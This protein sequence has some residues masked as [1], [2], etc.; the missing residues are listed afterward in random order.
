MSP[1]SIDALEDFEN[2]LSAYI[3]TVLFL[4][5]IYPPRIF[6]CLHLSSNAASFFVV[7]L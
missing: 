3:S 7:I 1:P 5:S 2:F 6:L 4:R